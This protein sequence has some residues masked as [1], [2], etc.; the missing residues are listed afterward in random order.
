MEEI[1]SIPSAPRNKP[2]VNELS[3]LP[4]R[5]SLNQ[6]IEAVTH[7]KLYQQEY[8]AAFIATMHSFSS[9]SIVLT[10]MAERCDCPSWESEVEAIQARVVLLL[11]QWLETQ[12]FVCCLVK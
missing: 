2:D 10:K 4:K 12:V 7:P 11:K 5:G 1:A 9:G 3:S 8:T 6:L